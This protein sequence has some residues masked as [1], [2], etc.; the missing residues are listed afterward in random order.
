MKFMN[1]EVIIG[2]NW[3]YIFEIF[4]HHDSELKDLILDILTFTPSK[5]LTFT[6]F[7][8]NE[9]DTWAS[10]ED[11]FRDIPNE[12]YFQGVCSFIQNNAQLKLENSGD[13][14]FWKEIASELKSRTN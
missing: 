5:G 12:S 11:F 13:A 4:Y 9:W 14:P 6:N 2:M 1:M 7:V 3:D 10:E 8:H